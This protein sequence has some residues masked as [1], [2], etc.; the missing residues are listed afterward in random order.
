MITVVTICYFLFYFLYTSHVFDYLLQSK[1]AFV[2]D[3]ES[4]YCTA[5]L[6]L[7]VSSF[8]CHD[9]FVFSTKLFISICC[10]YVFWLLL[11]AMQICLWDHTTSVLFILLFFAAH[12]CNDSFESGYCSDTTC[13]MPRLDEHNCSLFINKVEAQWD[14]KMCCGD[15]V[16]VCVCVYYS[17]V[18]NICGVK[19]QV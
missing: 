11:A 7:P 8:I 6:A 1:W 10:R 19:M 13:W 3:E 18:V 4:L 17:A 9:V 5:Q 12:K 2:K 14:G 16:C 15:R